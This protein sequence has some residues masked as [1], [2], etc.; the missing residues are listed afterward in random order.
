MDDDLNKYDLN[1]AVTSHPLM[2]LDEWRSVYREA[3]ET[4]YTDEHVEIVLRRAIA[5]G[6]SPGKTTFFIVWFKGCINIEKIHPLEGGFFRRKVRKNRRSGMKIENPLVFYPR[7]AAET[8]GKQLK[9]ISLY[10]RMRLIYRKVKLDPARLEYMDTALEPVTDHEEDREMF[11]TDA[12]RIYLDKVH[13]NDKISKCKN[14]AFVD[15]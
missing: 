10:L 13:R 2:S 6:T 4:Y 11:Q 12:A 7:Y 15:R 14:A 3:W 1:H 5:T 9:W 8:I